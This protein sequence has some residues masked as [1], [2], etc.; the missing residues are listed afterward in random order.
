MKFDQLLKVKIRKSKR[1]GRGIGSGKGKTSG[2]GTKGQKARGKIPAAFTGTPAFFKKLP[3]K[4]GLGN[5]KVS[6]KP[7]IL[8]LDKL[9]G[10]KA[11]AVVDLTKLLEEKIVSLKDVREGIKILGTGEIETA[12]TVKLSASAAARRKI[13]KA[14]GKVEY[15]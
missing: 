13:E 12:L 1:L 15:V 10:F 7:K 2:R 4:K 6:S 8:S 14:G 9:K 3:L 11:G 5:T